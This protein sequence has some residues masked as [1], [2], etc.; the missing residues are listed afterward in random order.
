MTNDTD[1]TIEKLFQ[2]QHLLISRRPDG[3]TRQE[4]ADL[5]HV[6]TRTISRYLERLQAEPHYLPLQFDEAPP[7]KW[8]VMAGRNVTLPPVHF[9]LED[10]IALTL[11][12]RLLSRYADR[13]NQYLIEA[14]AKLVAI[15]PTKAQ[16]YLHGV[17]D[18]MVRRDVDPV[19][20]HVFQTV[21]EG[22]ATGRVVAIEHPSDKTENGRKT[23]F[24][25]VYLIQPS[26]VGHSTYVIGSAKGDTHH[27]RTLK[28]ERALNA[29]LTE[30]TYQTPTDFDGVSLLDTAWEV[31][32]ADPGK[33]LVE[34]KLKFRTAHAAQR[35][36]E[37]YW[38]P[39]QDIQP[40]PDNEHGCLFYV[41]I[42]HT[43]EITP[44]IRQWGPDVEVI[45]PVDLRE[46]IAA[47]MRAAAKVYE[48]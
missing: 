8:R 15:I 44:W 6:S 9:K 38:H 47:Q 27:Y 39:S 42:A 32:Y 45:A 2:L 24:M 40:D 18:S 17:I 29:W 19:F 41:K 31:M 46:K 1:K 34:V 35:V 10:A 26:V 4:M 28:L 25:S 13:R 12:T 36:R 48:E 23:H 11:A 20:N 14:L 21:V 37:S 43:L 7:W 33:P 16:P 3:Y 30:E 22:W 5:C